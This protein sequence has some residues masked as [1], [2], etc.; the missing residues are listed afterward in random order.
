MEAAAATE[1]EATPGVRQEVDRLKEENNELKDKVKE[2]DNLELKLRQKMQILDEHHASAL[3]CKDERY[4]QLRREMEAMSGRGGGGS[5]G[6]GGGGGDGGGDGGGGGGGDGGGGNEGRG[7]GGGSGG[8]GSGAEQ[9]NSGARAATSGA[10]SGG[11]D[12]DRAVGPARSSGWQKA[13][14]C[15]HTP[16]K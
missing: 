8:S 12:R 4:Y 2:H 11:D 15:R 5:G 3:D 6:G 16:P 14:A 9:P 10:T 13:G 1:K 7:G